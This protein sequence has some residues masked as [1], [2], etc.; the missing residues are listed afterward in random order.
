NAGHKCSTKSKFRAGTMQSRLDGNLKDL[1]LNL[2]LND[3]HTILLGQG[4]ILFGNRS[5]HVTRMH[6]V[7]A[8][9]VRSVQIAV[10]S[11]APEF[12]GAQQDPESATPLRERR[13]RAAVMAATSAA[14]NATAAPFQGQLTL[15]RRQLK[16]H[17][18][19]QAGTRSHGM[20]DVPGSVRLV[21]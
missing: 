8:R 18:R 15:Y 13:R 1:S 20:W 10:K 2:R 11:R 9:S 5:G 14:A 21:A 12:A 4:Q 7:N 6:L 16:L 17:L 19:F 3:G